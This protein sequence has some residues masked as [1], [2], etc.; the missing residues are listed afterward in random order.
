MTGDGRSGVDWRTHR[1]PFQVSTSGPVLSLPPSAV[2]AVAEM[3]DTALNVV[4]LAPAGC[5]GA[6]T[7][8]VVPRQTTLIAV[9]VSSPFTNTP[10]APTAMQKVAFGHDTPPTVL[11]TFPRLGIGWSV[12]D[13]PSQRSANSLSSPAPTAVHASVALHEIASRN[14][15]AAGALG[16]IVQ[17]VPSH[18]PTSGRK[19]AG[20]N[21]SMSP[22]PVH[23][24][25]DVQAIPS[26]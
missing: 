21:V 16:W 1:P 2:H 10:S 13:A 22:T 17:S 20:A 5:N 23:N 15:P 8:H 7:D 6:L 14:P 12:Q 3:H 19:E 18:R 4:R 25:P 26:R 9:E 11:V 24:V